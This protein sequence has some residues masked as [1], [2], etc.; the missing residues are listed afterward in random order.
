MSEI[1]GFVKLKSNEVKEAAK[2]AVIHH[3]EWL[4][5]SFITEYNENKLQTLFYYLYLFLN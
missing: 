2:K 5:S 1:S 3:Y 4:K